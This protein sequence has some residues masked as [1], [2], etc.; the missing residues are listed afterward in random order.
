MDRAQRLVFVLLFATDKP[1]SLQKLAEICETDEARLRTLLSQIGKNLDKMGLCVIEHE[2]SYELVTKPEFAKSIQKLQAGQGDVLSPVGLEVLAII[3][4]RQPI[5][6]PQIDEIRGVG[7]EQT[8]KA[9]LNRKLITRRAEKHEHQ[10]TYG[11]TADFL[12]QLGLS[13]IS[14]LPRIKSNV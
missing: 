14:N 13:H 12:R 6:Q 2:R 5:S 3:A 7:S 4:Y 9:L 1:I 10:P 11:T 8:I